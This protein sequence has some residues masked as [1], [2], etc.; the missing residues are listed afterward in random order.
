MGS[1]LRYE[2]DTMPFARRGVNA[3]RERRRDGAPTTLG[4]L[5]DPEGIR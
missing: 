5:A 3:R 2:R 4:D 1:L